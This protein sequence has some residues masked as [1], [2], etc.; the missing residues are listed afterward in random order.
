MAYILSCFRGLASFI[1]VSDE[2]RP[3]ILRRICSTMNN[4]AGAR[5]SAMRSKTRCLFSKLTH[6][7]IR[8]TRSQGNLDSPLRD[9]SSSTK[10]SKFWMSDGRRWTS[11]SLK[12][13]LRSLLSRKKFCK[14]NRKFNQNWCLLSVLRGRDAPWEDPWCDSSRVKV[15]P[16]SWNSEECLRA[17][18]A[19]SSA[20]YQHTRL[21]DC[22]PW[23]LGCSGTF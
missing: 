4:A 23:K 13:S 12:P 16:G 20:S 2:I 8:K 18:F 9:T 5:P 15:L 14:P 1:C 3:K 19:G 7:K 10:F 22:S 11:L 6:T 17:P 21:A